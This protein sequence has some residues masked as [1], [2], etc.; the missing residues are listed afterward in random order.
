MLNDQASKALAKL[1][2]TPIENPLE[3]LRRLAGQVT[4]WKDQAAKMVNNLQGEMR[5]KDEKGAEQLRSEIVIW[6]RAL[7]RCV[8]TLAVMSKLDI[9]ERLARIEAAKVDMVFSIIE[10]TFDDLGLN[11]KQKSKLRKGFYDN[12][13]MATIEGKVIGGEMPEMITV[14]GVSNVEYGRNLSI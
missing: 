2:V 6:E 3:E 14:E 12:F 8:T 13:Q 5:Y 9:D 1:N 4:A 10:K 7:D 11:D